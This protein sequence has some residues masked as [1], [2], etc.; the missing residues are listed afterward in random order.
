MRVGLRV[1]GLA[2]LD[3]RFERLAVEYDD[4]EIG[5]LEGQDEDD[6]EEVRVEGRINMVRSY[7]C[8]TRAGGGWGVEG[9][10]GPFNRAVQ[11][12]GGGAWGCA[13]PCV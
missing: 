8:R 11:A 12:V 9:C 4:E 1:Q 5:A 3:A 10:D 7:F 13:W 6:D 2:T